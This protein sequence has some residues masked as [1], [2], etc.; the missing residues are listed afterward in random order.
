MKTL[1]ISLVLIS[2]LAFGASKPVSKAPVGPTQQQQ[3]QIKRAEAYNSQRFNNDSK[4]KLEQDTELMY[5]IKA[6]EE[7]LHQALAGQEATGFELGPNNTP[8]AK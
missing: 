3:D 2:S 7:A 6:L 1:A 8:E 4:A 5:E